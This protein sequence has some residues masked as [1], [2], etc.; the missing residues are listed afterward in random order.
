MDKK[1]HSKT[2]VLNALMV[3]G[4]SLNTLRNVLQGLGPWRS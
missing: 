2:A 4:S 3:F 1:T